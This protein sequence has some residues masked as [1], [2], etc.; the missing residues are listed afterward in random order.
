MSWESAF[1]VKEGVR[2]VRK[3]RF[4]CGEIRVFLVSWEVR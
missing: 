3:V 2:V 1:F 4:F